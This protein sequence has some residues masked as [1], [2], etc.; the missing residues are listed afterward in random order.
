MSHSEKWLLSTL[1]LPNSIDSIPTRKVDLH[2][3]AGHFLTAS[4]RWQGAWKGQ[5]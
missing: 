1:G 3:K 5:S 4:G 2:G